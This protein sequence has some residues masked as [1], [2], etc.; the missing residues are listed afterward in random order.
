M[1]P[2]TAGVPQWKRA[3]ME[4]RVNKVDEEIT[5]ERQRMEEEEEAYKVWVCA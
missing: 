3:L 1:D 5:R 2:D 4:K